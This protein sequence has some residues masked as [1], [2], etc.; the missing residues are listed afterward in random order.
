MDI[1]RELAYRHTAE[2]GHG[3]ITQQGARKGDAETL[4]LGTIMEDGRISPNARLYA[5][6][7]YT[8][9]KPPSFLPSTTPAPIRVMVRNTIDQTPS[10]AAWAGPSPRAEAR[11]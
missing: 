4:H 11:V 3:H 7:A 1:G 5:V 8:R 10:A 9:N 2:Q 6:F